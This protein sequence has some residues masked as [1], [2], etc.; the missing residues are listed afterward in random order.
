MKKRLS[1]LF[2]SLVLCTILL[3]FTLGG[4]NAQALVN[5]GVVTLAD[6]GVTEINLTGPYDTSTLSYGLPADWK[7]TG[8]A[9]IDLNITT[10]FNS[11]T[12]G[13]ETGV[14]RRNPGC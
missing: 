5:D 6:L 11:V 7:F 3:A 14:C 12:Q 4:V 1:N 10:T 13:N 2:S 8:N 9:K